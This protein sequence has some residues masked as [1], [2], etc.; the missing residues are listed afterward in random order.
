MGKSISRLVQQISNYS[1][2]KESDSLARKLEFILKGL[3]E[4]D[5][6][7]WVQSI[8]LDP[9]KQ[10]LPALVEDLNN[11]ET[12]FF[13]D[14]AQMRILET[15]ILPEMV[16]RKLL[17]GDKS[18]KIW[19]AA[20]SSGEETY[21]LAMMLLKTFIDEK[22]SVKLHEGLILPPHGWLIEINGTDISR[23]VICKAKEGIYESAGNGLSSF[24]NF[25]PAYMEY[26][27][28][29]KEYEDTLGNKKKIYR[30]NEVLKSFVNFDV[31]NLNSP[32]PPKSGYDLVLC[33]NLMIYLH[34]EAQEKVQRV[35]KSSLSPGGM[36]MFSAVDK[37]C[38]S[39][40]I[41]THREMGCVYY[42]K[43]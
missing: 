17:A 25:P 12:Y 42:E 18:I 30:V 7:Q 16:K 13:R 1:G 38:N 32:M 34:D 33:R 40:G 6:D 35:I 36:F 43:M 37:L 26:F 27:T 4:N 3:S 39:V 14:E 10:E 41:E 22:L 29:S 11:H 19:S 20:C 8:E 9:Y 24:R 21:T 15:K 31:F 28:L 23:Q 2:L 5:L